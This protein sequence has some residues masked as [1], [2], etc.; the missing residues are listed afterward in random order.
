M[1]AIGVVAGRVYRITNRVIDQMLDELIDPEDV[2]AALSAVPQYIAG[3]RYMF[4]GASLTAV[5]V[6]SGDG[7]KVIAL[8][9]TLGELV[10]WGFNPF[11]SEKECLLAA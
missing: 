2:K 3:D 10:S 7:Y 6:D 1:S 9:R 8:C 11:E 4:H 5:G